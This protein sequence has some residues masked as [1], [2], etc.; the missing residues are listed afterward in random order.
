[1]S[2]S[3]ADR[4]SNKPEWLHHAGEVI[5]RSEHRRLIFNLIYTGKAKIKTVAHLMKATGLPMTRVLDAGLALRKA[6]IIEQVKINKRIA[7]QKIDWIQPYRDK[8]LKLA[9]SQSDRAKLPTKRNPAG[10]AQSSTSK[11]TIKVTATVRIPKTRNKAKHVTIDDLDSFERVRKI[12]H[13]LAY[14]RM[15]EK[16]FK[17]GVAKILG[18]RADFKDWGGEQRDLS[19]SHAKIEGKRLRAA[20]AFKGPGTSGKLTPAKM[21]FNGDQIQRLAKCPADIFFVQYWGE[22]DDSVGEQ[23]ESFIQLKSYFEDRPLWY[24]VID[25]DDSARLIQAYRGQFSKTGASQIAR[26]K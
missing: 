18:E 22:V 7:Y 14:V 12:V 4:G 16:K 25:G 13:G 11:K 6:D 2:V 24:G 19:S 9:S 21:G 10:T 23:L 20:F 5:G 8:I 15:P 3:V 26:K 17:S 1:M